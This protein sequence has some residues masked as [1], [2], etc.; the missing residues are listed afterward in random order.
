MCVPPN[1]PGASHTTL[2]SLSRVASMSSLSVSSMSAARSDCSRRGV[3]Y[4]LGRVGQAGR[5]LGEGVRPVA[6]NRLAL[7]EDP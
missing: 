5:R 3:A 2:S 6:R 1:E 4:G 7:V